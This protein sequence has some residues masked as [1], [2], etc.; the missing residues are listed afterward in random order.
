MSPTDRAG[1]GTPQAPHEDAAAGT[2][3]KVFVVDDEP[4]L[5]CALERL[6]RAEGL[7]TVG[8]GSA[9]EFLAALSDDDVGCV[10]L[11][12]AMPGLDGLALQQRLASSRA[13]LAIV[14][15]TGHG[16]IPMSVQAVKAGAVDFLTKPVRSADLLRAVHAALE[17]AGARQSVA[18]AVA[19]LRAAYD[20]LT[21]REREVFRQVVA[22]RLN[23]VIAARLGTS[24]QTVKV[25]RGRVMDKLGVR[26]VADLVRAAQQL[27]VEPAP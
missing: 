19:R 5:R 17:L 4:D 1:G 3:A 9:A 15:L 24:E 27:G 7:A 11:D 22:G 10:V 20:L 12:V 14:F 21:P 23:K 26:S 25:H 2:H 8:Y 16:D 6:L 13:R 18:Q